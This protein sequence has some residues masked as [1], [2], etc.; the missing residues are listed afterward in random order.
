MA[1]PL[2]DLSHGLDIVIDLRFALMDEGAFSALFR[3]LNNDFSVSVLLSRDKAGG[4]K[5]SA[6]RQHNK[7]M[8]GY[9]VKIERF[10][11]AAMCSEGHRQYVRQLLIPSLFDCPTICRFL[12]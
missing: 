12:N 6:A 2:F 8:R 5:R 3:G 9:A 1:S 11:A 10:L 4:Q 7:W